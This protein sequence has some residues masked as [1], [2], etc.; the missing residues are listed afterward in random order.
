M[1]IHSLLSIDVP[2]ENGTYVHG[3]D[4]TEY[5][6]PAFHS[7]TSEDIT[8]DEGTY[9]F[10]FSSIVSSNLRNQIVSHIEEPVF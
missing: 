1:F 8:S 5:D 6:Y 7:L 2:F 3:I 9:Y 4:P 10:F